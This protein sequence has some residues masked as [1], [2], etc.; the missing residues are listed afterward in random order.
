MS[1]HHDSP[2]PE[3]ERK[4]FFDHPGNVTLVL[5]IFYC[6]ATFLAVLGFAVQYLHWPFHPHPAFAEEAAF[7]A[8]GF[9][10][11][12]PIFYCLYGFAA[13]VILVL[14]ATQLRKVLMRD[15]TYY[16]GAAPD[17]PTKED[18]S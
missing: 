18:A 14:L 3:G 11:S 6:A 4:Y 15:E 8:G 13:C 9:E 16:D 10:Q 12:I 17:G 1:E 7:A 5:R 2:V